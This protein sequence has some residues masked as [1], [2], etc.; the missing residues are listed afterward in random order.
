MSNIPADFVPLYGNTYPIKDQLKQLGARFDGDEKAWFL[1][2]DSI[3]KARSLVPMAD[4]DRQR[5]IFCGKW[6]S[7][8][9]AEECGGDYGEMFCGS[10]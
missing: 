10:C 5:C 7:A 2:P 8:Q 9:D 4:G 6:F 1:P 3:A